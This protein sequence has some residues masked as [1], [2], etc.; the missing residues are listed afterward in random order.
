MAGISDDTTAK[1]LTDLFCQ[2][3]E[4]GSIAP[5]AGQGAAEVHFT[6]ISS[7][8]SAKDALHGRAG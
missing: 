2:F 1:Q 4:I 5:L 7:A 3:G 8:I 6:S